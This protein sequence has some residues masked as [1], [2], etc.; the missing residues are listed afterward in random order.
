MPSKIWGATVKAGDLEFGEALQ[1]FTVLWHA[2]AAFARSAIDDVWRAQ[3]DPR[4]LEVIGEASGYS[5]A[6]YLQA[7]AAR[8]RLA[9]RMGEFHERFHLL[10]T[11]AVPIAAFEAGREVPVDWPERRWPTWT[12]F[13]YPFNLSHQQALSVPCGFTSDGLPVGL[14][15]VAGKYDD[16]LV[17]R[18]GH[19]FETEWPQRGAMSS[20]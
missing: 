10:A 17:L 5:L 20:C 1:A 6:T 8:S 7:T 15:I 11:P 13:S 4:L 19:A 12:P 14:Q 3:M 2:G 18:A 9:I 16:A